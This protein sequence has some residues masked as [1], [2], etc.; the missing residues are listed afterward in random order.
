MSMLNGIQYFNNKS[1]ML[2]SL[3]PTT[4]KQSLLF[5]DFFNHRFYHKFTHFTKNNMLFNQIQKLCINKRY[6]ANEII[7]DGIKRKPYLDLEKVFESKEIFDKI[8]SPFVEKLIKD[9]VIIFDTK[10]NVKLDATDILLLNSS[11]KVSDGYKISLHVVISPKDKTYY[12]TNNK[13]TD[14]S[15]VHFFTSL[16]ELDPTYTDFLDKQVYNK[17]ANMRMILSHKNL[18]DDRVLN[19][20]DLYT[21]NVLKLNSEQKL[22]YLIT[23]VSIDKPIHKLTTPLITPLITNVQNKHAQKNVKNKSLT[24]PSKNAPSKTNLDDAI[25]KL[26]KKFHPSGFYERQSNNFYSFNFKD[27]SEK[28][29]L[30]GF[31]HSGKNGFFLCENDQGFFMK[32]RSP[33]CANATAKYIGS[34]DKTDKFINDAIHINSKFILDSP[35][36]TN[37]LD[38]WV[39]N[40]KTFC[41]K[42]PMATGKTFTIKH[43]LKNYQFKKILWITHRQSLTKSLYGAFQKFD[44]VNYMDTA[45]ELFDYDKVIVQL[46]SLMRISR[47]DHFDGSTTFKK[48]DL[49]IID[50]IESLLNHLSS[51]FLSKHDCSARELFTNL[52]NIINYSPK[53]LLLDADVADRTKLFIK[54]FPDSTFIVNDF[55]PQVKNFTIT[56]CEDHFNFS[57]FADIDNKK[58]VCVISMSSNALEKIVIELKKRRVEYVLHTSKTSD[59]LKKN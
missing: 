35:I 52:T 51:P 11:G 13:D 1:D 9:I 8:F 33:R 48:Y 7:I 34:I 16:L 25:L 23:Y 39:A 56:N 3:S 6:Y 10:Y 37:Y 54:N 45:G 58:N 17:D 5:I 4:N 42:S 38:D 32:C 18:G 46:D 30:T 49:V 14:S 50:E 24:A 19:P 43:I 36:V 27:R 26:V 57:L 55:K 28:C 44:F 59:E 31:I 12:Y 41:I 47:F 53:L 21:H 2:S 22:D 40:K 20:I 29:P 15:A